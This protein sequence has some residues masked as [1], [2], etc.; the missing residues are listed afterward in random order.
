MSFPLI[1]RSHLAKGDIALLSY[2]PGG[3]ARREFVPGGC[4][5]ATILGMGGRIVSG[6]TIRKSD[7]RLFI[8]TIAL[9]LTIQFQFDIECLRDSNH[10]VANF[11]NEWI[12]RYRP[13]PKPNFNTIW[14]G[15][16]AVVCKE[17][18]SIYSAI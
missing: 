10:F 18:V 12:D 8:V 17:I 7:G 15:D 4:I 14:E 11:G 9:S 13:R 5:G 3:S 16:G 1:S 2:S 6:N